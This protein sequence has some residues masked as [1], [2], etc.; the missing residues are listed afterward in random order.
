M[1]KVLSHNR[2]RMTPT[3]PKFQSLQEARDYISGEDIECLICHKR[4][5][6]LT[7]TH[8]QIHSLTAD[9]Y[10]AQF[11]IPWSYPLNG[12]R[13]R[14]ITSASHNPKSNLC[15]TARTQFGQ[16]YPDRRPYVDAQKNHWRNYIRPMGPRATTRGADGRFVE[17]EAA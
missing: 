15:L 2:V 14:R 16:K 8:L 9:E 4:M 13:S 17:K 5:S 1:L 7:G 11:G 12:A 6:R 10:R 3:N